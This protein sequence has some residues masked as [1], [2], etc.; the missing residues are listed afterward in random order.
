MSVAINGTVP[1]VAVLVEFL[2]CAK[3]GR[4]ARFAYG[5]DGR[6]ASLH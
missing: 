4:N 2:I 3:E 6:S 1:S 5:T